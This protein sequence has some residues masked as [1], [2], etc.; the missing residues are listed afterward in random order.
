MAEVLSGALYTPV[1]V[2]EGI[3]LHVVYVWLDQALR[4]VL[5]FIFNLLNIKEVGE[6][7]VKGE[8]FTSISHSLDVKLIL[9]SLTGMSLHM[10]QDGCTQL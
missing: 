3:Y 9:Y 8:G 2:S 10:F 5:I 1:A 4:S 6:M 7:L